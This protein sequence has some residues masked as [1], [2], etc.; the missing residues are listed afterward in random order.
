MSNKS[1][2]EAVNRTLQDLRDCD[3]I[4]GGLTLLLSC[5]FRQTLPV[6]QRGTKADEIEACIKCSFYGGLQLCC[7]FLPT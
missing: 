2:V 7:H 5:D 3:K 4:M 6:I 1:A